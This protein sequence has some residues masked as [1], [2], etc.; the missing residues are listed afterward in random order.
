MLHYCLFNNDKGVM[1]VANKADTVIEII[2]KIKNIYKLLPFFLKGG[3]INWNTRSIVFE[4]GCRIK[5]SART[6]EPAIG[7]TIDFLYMDEFAHVPNTIA[8]AYYKA[9]IPTV[10][11]IKDSKII[12]T[13]TPN[14]ANL[15]KELVVSSELPETHPDKGMYNVIRV[16]WYQVPDGKFKDDTIATRLDARLYYSNAELKKYNINIKDVFK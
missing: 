3:I 4:N 12:I 5:S 14:G 6:K 13:S 11:S 7:F 16:Y 1:I 8:R 15:F 9:V 10:S 2:D